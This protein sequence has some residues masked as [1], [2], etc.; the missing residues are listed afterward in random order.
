MHVECF[1]LTNNLNG[2]KSR[3]KRHLKRFP[4]CFNLFPASFSCNSMHC[5][6]S[7]VLD[8]LNPNLKKIELVTQRVTSF[9]ITRFGNSVS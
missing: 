2:F 7:S 3:I 4:V 1:P 8:G 5:S 9:C 6:G